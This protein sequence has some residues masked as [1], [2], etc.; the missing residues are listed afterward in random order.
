MRSFPED[1]SLQ[2][3]LDGKP[4]EWTPAG[5]GYDRGFHDYE[6]KET[7]AEGTHTIEWTAAARP[8]GAPIRQLCSLELLEYYEGYHYSNDYIGAYPVYDSTGRQ[9]G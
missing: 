6:I 7:L 3:T 2:V 1:G 8:A 5:I 9:R 4:F